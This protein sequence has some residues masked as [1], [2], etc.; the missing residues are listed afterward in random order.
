MSK[1]N[2]LKVTTKDNELSLEEMSGAL[3]DTSTIMSMVG[4]A[5]WRLIY[6]ARG[7]NWGLADYYFRRVNK[8][9]DTL[10]VLRPKH[11]ER[12]ERF[13]ATAMPPVSAAIETR[14]LAGLE[15]SYTEATDMANHLHNE[16]GYPY[17]KWVLPEEKPKGLQ[18]EPVVPPLDDAQPS[19]DGE[20]A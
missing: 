20:R 3:P 17:I 19:P 2:D 6:A 9:E 4:D 16:S 10:K 14:D 5:W 13:Q 8:L 12:L 11:R 1:D 18:L 15:K 7:G